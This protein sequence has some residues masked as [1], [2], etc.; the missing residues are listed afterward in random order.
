MRL[1]HMHGD[2]DVSVRLRRQLY[3]IVFIL[4]QEYGETSVIFFGSLTTAFRR[5][6]LTIC[7]LGNLAYSQ[8]LLLD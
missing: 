2:W 5:T 8:N 7:G 6:F 4:L 3:E 1:F